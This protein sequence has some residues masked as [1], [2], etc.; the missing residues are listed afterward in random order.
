M[1]VE[2]L[3]LTVRASIQENPDPASPGASAGTASS[4]TTGNGN[5]GTH[6]I[7]QECVARVMEILRHKQE[8]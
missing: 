6:E 1:P 2:I 7:V 8:R 3:E 4:G 5:T